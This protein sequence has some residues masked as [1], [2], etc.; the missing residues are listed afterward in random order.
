MTDHHDDQP[1]RKLS[2]A[3]CGRLGGNQT[4]AR[5]GIE[6]FRRAGKLGFA[7]FAR[8][9]GFMGG[10]RLEALR[11]LAR[12]GKVATN[13]EEIRRHDEAYADLARDLGLEDTD[14]DQR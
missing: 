11:W 5:H 4:K 3:E 2:K 1:T 13:P 14:H 8:Q 12:H 6:H 10:S 7:A 9:K